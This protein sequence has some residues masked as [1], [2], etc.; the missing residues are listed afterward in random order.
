MREREK[1]GERE[2]GGGETL[3]S[4]LEL[5]SESEAVEHTGILRINISSDCHVVIT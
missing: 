4:S 5:L 2:G 3:S 1:R